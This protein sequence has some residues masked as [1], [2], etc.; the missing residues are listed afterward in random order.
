MQRPVCREKLV[1]NEEGINK[2]VAN[3]SK[4]LAK[5]VRVADSCRKAGELY[6]ATQTE[7]IVPQTVVYY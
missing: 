5:K 1:R 7:S 6:D 3:A 4:E 2:N